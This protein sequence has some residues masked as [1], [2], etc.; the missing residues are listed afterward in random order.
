M[1]PYGL[2]PLFAVSLSIFY[3]LLAHTTSNT[4]PQ[5]TSKTTSSSVSVPQHTH[6]KLYIFALGWV[7][8]FG[9]FLAGLYWIGN[10]LLVEGNA[11]RWLYPFALAGL[12]ALFAFY[13]AL[14]GLLASRTDLKRLRGFLY[15]VGIFALSEWA[16]GTLLTGFP[17][18]LPAHIWAGHLEMSQLVALIGIYGLSLLTILGAA[19]PGFIL[20][21]RGSPK[22]IWITAIVIFSLFA[23]TYLYGAQRLAQNPTQYDEST[24]I[25]LIQPNI[26]QSQKWE[27]SAMVSNF[28]THMR[29][30]QKAGQ[31]ISLRLPRFSPHTGQTPPPPIQYRYIIWP[32]TALNPNILS[33]P[34]PKQLITSLLNSFDETTFLLSGVLRQ[35]ETKTSHETKDGAAS[36]ENTNNFAYYNSLIVYNKAGEQPALF[37]KHHLV[38]FGEYIP[39]ENWVNIAPLVGFSGFEKGN[40]PSLLQAEKTSSS[41]GFIPLICYEAIFPYMSRII[42]PPQSKNTNARFVVNVTNDG[43]YGDSAGPYQHLAQSVFRAI[44]TG[45]PLIRVAN[46]GIS[47]LID[48]Y[49]REIKYISY[50][51]ESYEVSFLPRAALHSNFYTTYTDIPFFFTI[52]LLI[53]PVG[54]G[55]IIRS[56]IK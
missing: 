42:P 50:G 12:P 10:A 6:R 18:N 34:Q 20:V 40:G 38:P 30:T 17:W 44:E 53:I 45:L 24:E 11:Y 2:W 1:A 7:F 41:P 3:I 36:K 4:V 26:A 54:V 5:N 19:L 39:F 56:S 49:G 52:F 37:D 27:R 35:A 33:Q 9:Y 48:P 14:V 32:E 16:R 23:L 22:H 15:F 25:I 55:S 43:W 21:H 51:I 28:L 46:T 47:A 8:G 13:P 31:E 29:L